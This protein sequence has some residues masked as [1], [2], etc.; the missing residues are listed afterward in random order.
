M[1][2]EGDGRHSFYQSLTFPGSRSPMREE[3]PAPRQL[4]KSLL[5]ECCL[6]G[7]LLFG[8]DVSPHPP[9]ALPAWVSNYKKK[10]SSNTYLTK[11]TSKCVIRN[12]KPGRIF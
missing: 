7:D 11:N 9:P 2:V 12:P 1:R 5:P 4:G 6:E 3:E 10:G 8:L